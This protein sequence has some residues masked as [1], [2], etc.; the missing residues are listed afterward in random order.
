MII[1]EFW[2]LFVK[3]FA[4]RFLTKRRKFKKD[5][6]NRANRLHPTLLNLVDPCSLLRKTL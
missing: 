3:S 5:F 6:D 2:S 4:G 1:K